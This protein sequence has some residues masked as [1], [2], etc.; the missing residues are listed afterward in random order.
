M[1]NW[2]SNEL[3]VTGDNKE[4]QRFKKFMTGYNQRFKT[5]H[6]KQSKE[7]VLTNFC[8]SNVIKIPFIYRYIID[9]SIVV[10]KFKFL[11]GISGYSWA[12]N[13]W[14]TKWNVTDVSVEERDGVLVYDFETAWNPPKP[15]IEK[16]IKKFPKLSFSFRY[17]EEGMFFAGIIEGEDGDIYTDEVFTTDEEF[18]EN[19]FD[20]MVYE[21]E[22]DEEEIMFPMT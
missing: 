12:C 9:Y 22:E 7:R 4:L 14:G 5:Y 13:N 11:T 16:L 17:S 21:D 3:T 19:G 18:K 6:Q 15:V 2:C 20:Y 1:P 10:P 8:F